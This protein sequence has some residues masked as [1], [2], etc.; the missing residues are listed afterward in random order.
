[1]NAET[2][3]EELVKLEDWIAENESTLADDELQHYALK[4]QDLEDRYMTAVCEELD[5]LMDMAGID[6]EPYE[7]DFIF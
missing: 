7:P 4:I 6:E 3:R 2:L 5:E 1:M